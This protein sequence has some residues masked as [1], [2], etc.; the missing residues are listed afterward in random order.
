MTCKGCMGAADSMQA[1]VCIL[2]FQ[3]DQR[4]HATRAAGVR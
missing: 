1:P 4:Q 2:L 3:K